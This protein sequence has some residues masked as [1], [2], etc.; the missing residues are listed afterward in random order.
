MTVCDTDCATGQCPG[1]GQKPGRILSHRL[2]MRQPIIGGCTSSS[3]DSVSG[4]FLIGS[5]L[6]EW[7]TQLKLVRLFK[8][9][10][11]GSLAE[12]LEARYRGGYSRRFETE[13][14]VR[15]QP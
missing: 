11:L 15:I 6:L 7:V 9:I 3:V 8:P 1:Y 14:Y 10:D 2:V 5:S 13:L 12:R 4:Y